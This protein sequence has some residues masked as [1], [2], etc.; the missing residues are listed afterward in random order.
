MVAAV[1][2]AGLALRLLWLIAGHHLA[3]VVAEM[4]EIAQ[5]YA[6]TGVVS[7]A[8]HFGSG[9]TAHAAPLWPLLIGGVYR[10]F[11]LH[12]A[13]SEYV[14][15]ALSLLLVAASVLLFERVMARLGTPAW[16]RLAAV[17]FVAL[18]P[19]NFELEVEL[20]RTWE[21]AAAAAIMALFLWLALQLDARPERPRPLE[22][23]GLAALVAPVTMISPA[24]ALGAYGCLGLL[25]LRRR[26]VLAVPAVTAL[27]LLFV[28]LLSYPWA[29]RNERVLGEP[30]W[31]R[32]NFGFVFAEGF[33]AAAVAPAD[34]KR[35]FIDRMAEI[36]PFE[37]AKGFAALTAAG[38]E[39]GYNRYWTARTWAWVG[40]HRIDAARIA[41][42]HVGEFF[43]PP[44]WLWRAYTDDAKLVGGKQ[45]L[46]W[47]IAILGFLAVAWGLRRRDQRYW[48]VLAMLVLPVAPYILAQPV[49]R[50]R[51]L[52]TTLLVFL[53]ADCV[54]R[55]VELHAPRRVPA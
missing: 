45:A 39:P 48:Y 25:A 15:T 6:R 41:V 21:Q 52:I 47:G 17:A 34:P 2:L 18:V 50:Y 38:G 30:V 37:R 14:L 43:L 11:G 40:A 44:Q 27:S 16:A 35:V 31:S 7:D 4:Y 51:Y 20:L 12:S 10:L 19:L 24:A 26:G 53:A 46:V 55:A 29:L 9:P 8:Y 5:G 33:H 3:P 36:D 28:V 54:G 23:A 32:S 49:L 13:L 42:R 22:L 1:L